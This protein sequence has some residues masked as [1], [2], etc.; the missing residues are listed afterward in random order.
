MYIES[1]STLLSYYLQIVFIQPF[2]QSKTSIIHNFISCVPRLLQFLLVSGDWYSRSS[3]RR[4]VH[5]WWGHLQCHTFHVFHLA[6]NCRIKEDNFNSIEYY[7]FELKKK[8]TTQQDLANRWQTGPR[9][10]RNFSLDFWHWS[11]PLQRGTT[12]QSKL[13][14]VNSSLKKIFVDAQIRKL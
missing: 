4:Q 5:Q 13:K 11:I 14:N 6:D 9:G 10:H 12:H 1:S 7:I 8:L 2:T 3:N